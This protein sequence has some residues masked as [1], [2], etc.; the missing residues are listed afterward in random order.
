MKSSDSSSLSFVLVEG[1][2]EVPVAFLVPQWGRSEVTPLSVARGRGLGWGDDG[3]KLCLLLVCNVHDTVQYRP[4]LKRPTTKRKHVGWTAAA[5]ACNA[6]A[7][8]W[9]TGVHAVGKY[10]AG[11]TKED[12]PLDGRGRQRTE[13]KETI[14]TT[15]TES[16]PWWCSGGV[17]LVV[18]GTRLQYL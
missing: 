4:K 9:M 8:G 18:V 5:T 17:R 3:S 12:C 2:I 7:C 15:T 11:D 1:W 6:N 13:R 16:G 14:D 10:L